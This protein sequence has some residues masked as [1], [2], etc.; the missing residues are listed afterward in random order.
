MFQNY[1]NL[2]NLLLLLSIILLI[3]FFVSVMILYF[4]NIFILKYWLFSLLTFMIGLFCLKYSTTIE[5]IIEKNI[6]KF[7][8]KNILNEK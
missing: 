7:K 5:I 8:L 1:K 4:N 3:I 2:R 6:R